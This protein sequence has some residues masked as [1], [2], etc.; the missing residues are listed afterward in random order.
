MYIYIMAYIDI[1]SKKTTLIPHINNKY[2][3]NNKQTILPK[4]IKL[5][6][7]NKI[8][9]IFIKKFGKL[10]K[11]LCLDFHG[12]TDLYDLNEKIPSKLDKCVISYIGKNPNT[13]GSTINTIVSRIKSK[14]IKLG[15]IVYIK[16]EELLE[17]TKGSVINLLINT[18]PELIIYFIDDSIVNIKC[19]NNIKN[20]NLFTYFINKKYYPKN[21][22]N[23]L[24][25]KINNIID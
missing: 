15:I 2:D 1:I 17:G 9:K 24:L 8:K 18:L 25:Y 5:T 23:K 22:L 19:V 4:R 21:K 16:N 7:I 6:N 3:F 13:L 11:L 14:E 20:N 12:I 10:K